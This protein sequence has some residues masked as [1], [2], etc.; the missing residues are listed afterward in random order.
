MVTVCIFLGSEETGAGAGGERRARLHAGTQP[1]RARHR[2]P[3]VLV[4]AETIEDA[5]D[6]AFL[7]LRRGAFPDRSRSAWKV[8]KV[9]TL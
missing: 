6:A 2:L 8:D 9:E 7:K 5:E 1:P 4:V 3:V